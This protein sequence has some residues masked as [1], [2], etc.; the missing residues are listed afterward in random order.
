L[1]EGIKAK[2]TKEVWQ[3]VLKMLEKELKEGLVQMTVDQINIPSPTGEEA[4]M[5][6]YIG[7]IPNPDLGIVIASETKQSRFF[8]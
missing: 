5:S 3:E 1:N 7:F 8:I 4:G 6:H 2:T